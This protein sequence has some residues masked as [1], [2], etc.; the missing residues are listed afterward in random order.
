MR[1]RLCKG[2]SRWREGHACTRGDV[3]DL[4][5]ESESD[6]IQ[7]LTPVD[8]SKKVKR[9]N[10]V[11][12]SRPRAFCRAPRGCNTKMERVYGGQGETIQVGTKRLA[13]AILH[14]DGSTSNASAGDAARARVGRQPAG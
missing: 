1:P 8:G 9:G 10:D 13:I 3:V 7:R 5:G 11:I 2:P 14:L 12:D 4:G 6:V